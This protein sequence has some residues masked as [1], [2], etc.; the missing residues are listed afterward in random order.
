MKSVN[1]LSKFF[2]FTANIILTGIILVGI[3]IGFLMITDTPSKPVSQQIK[4]N[5]S[6]ESLR[7]PNISTINGNPEKWIIISVSEDYSTAKVLKED[8]CVYYMTIFTATE[9]TIDIEVN[10]EIHAFNYSK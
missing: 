7:N 1:T 5:Y 10:G 9:N 2:H 8:G 3:G 4:V 6:S